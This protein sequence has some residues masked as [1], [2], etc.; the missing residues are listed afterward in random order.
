[1]GPA[2][3]VLVGDGMLFEGGDTR[4]FLAGTGLGLE[5]S[6]G[7]RLPL[8]MCLATQIVIWCNI[9]RDRKGGIIFI[10]R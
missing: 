7:G 2:W 5:L 4:P 9:R 8:N 3:K 10:W 1:M 6:V